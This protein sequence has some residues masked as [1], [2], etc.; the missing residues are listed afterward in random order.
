MIFGDFF[1]FCLPVG[2]ESDFDEVRG[3]VGDIQSAQREERHW[4]PGPL[5]ATSD[6]NEHQSVHITATRLLPRTARLHTTIKENTFQVIPFVIMPLDHSQL[7]QAGYCDFCL[8][9]YQR[10]HPQLEEIGIPFK[11]I[12][13]FPIYRLSTDLSFTRTS[14]IIIRPRNL[15]VNK[16]TINF[17]IILSAVLCNTSRVCLQWLSFWFTPRGG[18]VGKVYKEILGDWNWNP[19]RL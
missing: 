7:L 1:F 6:S 18:T 3:H 16:L 2:R 13:T 15:A 17:Q 14:M 12:Q 4:D 10:R 8:L 11:P 19:F 5:Q 9:S